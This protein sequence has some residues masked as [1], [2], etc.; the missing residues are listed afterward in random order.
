M[1]TEITNSE[2]L[3]YSR[4]I[5][6]RIDDLSDQVG[7]TLYPS[8]Q[9][10]L[11]A[12]LALVADTKPYASDWKYGATLI[13]DSYF[14]VHAQ[15]FAEGLGAVKG[16]ASWPHTCIDWDKAAADLQCDYV[17]VEFDGVTYWARM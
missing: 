8:E 10:E 2:D 3:I 6:A 17:S 5:I 11:V 7:L 13:R 16:A 9:S 14:K 15:D 12:L 4:D 1:S